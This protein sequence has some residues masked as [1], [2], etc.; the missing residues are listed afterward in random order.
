[1]CPN[2]STSDCT[3]YLCKATGCPLTCD[4]DADCIPADYCT[5]PG[6]HCV[7]RQIAGVTCTSDDQCATG[8][9][10]DGYCCG[11]PSCGPC[12]RC[13]LMGTEGSCTKIPA[14][15]PDT[16]GTCTAAPTSSCGEDGMCNGAG[17]CELWPAT[18]Q[19]GAQ[20]CPA[21]TAQVVAPFCDG[22]GNCSMTGTLSNC[23][24]LMCDGASACL[25][26]C[27]GDSDCL[28]GL[29]VAGACL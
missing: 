17:G 20:S 15:H 26:S 13:D 3:P 2:A 10:T 25:L 8:H 9:C 18:T 21:G 6:G 7:A 1:M 14:G 29:C 28:L 5:G 12:A 11:D 23:S 22:M 16:T 19:C 27:S 24:P 4:S